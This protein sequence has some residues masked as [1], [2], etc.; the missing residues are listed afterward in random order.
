VDAIGVTAAGKAVA[1]AMRSR[2]GIGNS[3]HHYGDQP[4]PADHVPFPAYPTALIHEVGGWDEKLAVNQDFEFDYRLGLQGYRLL[5][6]PGLPIAYDCQQSLRGLFRQFR[7]YGSGK[8]KVIAK[9]P[10]SVR[11]RHLVPPALVGWTAA[12]GVV[13]VRRPGLGLAGMAPYVAAL[14]AATAVAVGQLDDWR[15]R[16]RLPAAFVAMHYAWGLGFWEGAAKLVLARPGRRGATS[17]AVTGPSSN[18]LRV[19]TRNDAGLE[20]GSLE[21]R[22]A[23][24]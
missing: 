1:A 16:I 13:A 9:H 11:A 14:T 22:G 12:M 10:R 17:A 18:G 23:K 21:S 7:R 4:Q 15:A 20:T 2:F 3:V 19:A 6:D 5:Y 24:R 8:V